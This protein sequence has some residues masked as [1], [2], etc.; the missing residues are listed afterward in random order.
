[1]SKYLPFLH[2]NDD[3]RFF[4]LD[5]VEVEFSLNVRKLFDYSHGER[6]DEHVV[7]KLGLRIGFFLHTAQAAM[8]GDE[9]VFEKFF[10]SLQECGV[11]CLYALPTGYDY[12]S[13]NEKTMEVT[14]YDPPLVAKI[15]PSASDFGKIRRGLIGLLFNQSYLFSPCLTYGLLD[16]NGHHSLFLGPSAFIEEVLGKRVE[17]TWEPVKVDTEIES[18]VLT[19]LRAAMEAY[20]IS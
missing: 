9:S 14:E 10:S 17:D 20:G 6:F 5:P 11:T 13:L 7:G 2:E 16:W 18:T 1:M 4:C 8:A 12:D 15:S 3:E 19:R